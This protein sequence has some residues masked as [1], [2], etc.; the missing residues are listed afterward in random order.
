MGRRGNGGN[1]GQGMNWCPPVKRLA[2]YLRDGL[3]CVYC[4]KGADD[5][6][7]LT[8]DHLVPR[9]AGG[10]HAATNLVTACATCN[11]SR[12]HRPWRDGRHHARVALVDR[13]RRRTLQR[14]WA[15]EL[16]EKYANVR[17]A[18]F[19]GVALGLSS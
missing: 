7:V 1:N 17:I 12:C 2:I 6:Q 13:L 16:L 4:D 10:T 19:P 14:V 18:S 8:L 3:A 11:L 5:G 15:R 9:V